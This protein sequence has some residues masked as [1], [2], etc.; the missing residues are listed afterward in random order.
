MFSEIKET[1]LYS[2]G[3]RLSCLFNE[4]RLIFKHVNI[5]AENYILLIESFAVLCFIS[6]KLIF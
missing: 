1:F 5:Y 6:N 4:N 3:F 2:K